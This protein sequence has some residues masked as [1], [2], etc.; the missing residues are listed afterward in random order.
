MKIRAYKLAEELG[1]DRTEFVEK[2][3]AFGIELK[4]AMAALDP[5]Q[6]EEL[7]QKLGGGG[8]GR[9]MEERRVEHKGSKAIIRR[10]RKV[11]AEPEPDLQAETEV[12]E[13]PEDEVREESVASAEESAPETT[14]EVAAEGDSASSEEEPEGVSPAEPDPA[15]PAEGAGPASAEAEARRG[16][17]TAPRS[18]TA[19]PDGGTDRKGRQRKRVREVVNLQEQE[20][21]ARQVTGRRGVQ[22]RPVGGAPRT[23]QNPR[24]R[25]RDPV[26]KKALVATAAVPQKQTVRL[27]GDITVGEL[28]KQLGMK[29]A[30][31]QG[32]LMA[33]GTM[34]SVNQ[35]V[36]VDVV[37]QL[38]QQMGFEVQDVGF[39]EEEYLEPAPAV[40]EEESAESSPR[41]PII[42]VMGHVDHGK[43][44]LL[45]AIRETKVVD[46]ESG[47][48]TQHIGAYQVEA[49]GTKLTFID[50]PG[51]AAFTE[52]RA[53][54]AKV[55]DIVVLVVAATDGVMPQTV[56]AIQ[57]AQAAGSPIVVAVNKCDL[58]TANPQQARQKLMEHGLVPEEV[59]GDIVCVD[60]SAKTG[61]GL[62]QLLEMVSL[63]AE[64]LELK[65]SPS[66]RAS[67]VVLEAELDKGR[68]PLSTVLIVDGTLNRGD[69]MV[70]GNHH[71]RVRQMSDD[72]GG[73]LQSAPPSTPV[74]VVG[75]G[76]VPGAGDSFHVVENERVA[77]QIVS[78]REE[79]GRA[80]PE[81]P[82]PPVSLEDFFAQAGGGGKKK[83]PVVLKA[84]VQ[85]TC[86]AVRDSL[87]KL[88][89]DEVEINVLSAGVG[90]INENDIMLAKASGAIVV[91]FHVRPDAATRHQAESQ[92]VDVRVYRVIMELVDE[93]RQA[94]AGLLPPTVKEN[95]LGQAEVREI[96]TVPRVGSVAGSFITEGHIRRNAQCRLIR[97]GIEI[98][99]G[100]VGSLRRFK[101]DVRDVQT[102]FECGVGI[103][104]YGDV[105]VGDIIEAYELQEEPATL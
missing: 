29:A 87:E 68:G 42:T 74:R 38:A 72:D 53:R 1:I 6:V 59:G 50:T 4:N 20:Q 30:Q 22:R 13:Q 51:H 98:Y 102:G 54:G 56:E 15:A 49:N 77:K 105:K 96:F 92:G 78:H 48:I 57:H 61:A 69:I 101:E 76:G 33:L 80:K 47:G 66:R 52:M 24:A 25:R 46:G 85:G 28:A 40:A 99:D 41:P 62:D 91:G 93:V 36:D 39:K 19:A 95:V 21:F 83:L 27:E 103:D 89:T 88:G 11:V 16:S 55:T 3:L 45:D 10:R 8:S 18:E 37:G 64:L 44:S 104:G 26:A 60:V 70:V 75:L 100:R 63:Q 9:S 7:R 84:D 73:R 35:G 58:P 32:Q 2:A 31:L 86:E 14:E 71:G 12:A 97:D 23:A 82:A 43:T 5:E 90:G 94:M 81:A 17:G 79:R 34:V 67:G 65:A